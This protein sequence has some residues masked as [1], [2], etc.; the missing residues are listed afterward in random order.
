MAERRIAAAQE[1]GSGFF[2]EEAHHD[3]DDAGVGS[4]PEAHTTATT[5]KRSRPFREGW[6]VF[7]LVLEFACAR[8]ARAMRCRE[9]ASWQ[10]LLAQ[11]ERREPQEGHE[12][13]ETGAEGTGWLR[14][15]WTGVLAPVAGGS[16]WT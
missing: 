7:F 16:W 11:R 9:P 3:R 15:A 6:P 12:C 2:F 14:G 4:F 13:Q 5:G 1:G 10:A 8:H